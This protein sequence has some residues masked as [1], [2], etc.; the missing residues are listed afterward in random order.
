[1]VLFERIL[2]VPGGLL[3]QRTSLAENIL[4]VWHQ[5]GPSAGTVLT[6][7]LDMFLKVSFVGYKRNDVNCFYADHMYLKW[8]TRSLYFKGHS[9][10]QRNSYL[11]VHSREAISLQWRH[12]EG[13]GVSNQRRLDGLLNR[14]FRRK[15]KKTSKP[16]VTGICERNSPVTGEFH[17]QRS[18]DAENVFIWWRHYVFGNT[19]QSSYNT[20]DLHWKLL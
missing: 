6:P 15:S 5:H 9:H 11:S 2:L 3:S 17:S 12:N 20:V 4:V 16:R 1:M 18:S 14:L 13:D 10:W 19:V 7:K 8:S